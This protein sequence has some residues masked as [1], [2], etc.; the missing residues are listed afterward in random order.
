M[1]RLIEDLLAFSRVNT[2][3]RPSVVVSLDE[4]VR[5]VLSDLEEQ[6]RRTG[7]RVSVGPLPTLT[8]DPAQVGQLFQNLIGNALKFNR[9][10][11]S[12]EVRVS[13][14]RL[15]DL[16]PTADPPPPPPGWDGWRITVA[17]NGIGFEAEHSD[18]IFE[19]F[20]RLHGRTKYEGTGLGLA[21]VKKIVAR[22]GGVIAARGR[23]GEGAEFIIDWPNQTGGDGP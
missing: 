9:A 1:R 10:G 4:V 14:V 8:A 20:Q 11:V 18:R 12:P 6:L 22:H 19:L 16:P 15:S 23:P 7:G 5:D 2:R 13:T 21:I 3:S 17:D